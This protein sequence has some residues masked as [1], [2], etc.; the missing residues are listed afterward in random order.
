MDVTKVNVP[1]KC[2]SKNCLQ[3]PAMDIVC[4]EINY[5]KEVKQFVYECKNLEH[6]KFLIKNIKDL[7]K[8]LTKNG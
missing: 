1:V 7:N 8:E 6:C 5:G 4:N 2:L 3:C